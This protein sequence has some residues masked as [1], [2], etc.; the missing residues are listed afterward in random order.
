M[1]ATVRLLGS[2]ELDTRVLV[3]VLVVINEVNHS[4]T[5]SVDCRKSSQGIGWKVLDLNLRVQRTS[6]LAF[7]TQGRDLYRFTSS[8]K[9]Y[10]TSDQP[11]IGEPLSLWITFGATFSVAMALFTVSFSCSEH[12]DS[13]ISHTNRSPWN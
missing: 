8:S 9:R 10:S 5:Y 6:T 4:L 2:Y 1:L 13:H 11:F 3:I 12:S 7:D